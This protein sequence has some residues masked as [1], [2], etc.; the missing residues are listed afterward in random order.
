MENPDNRTKPLD[1]SANPVF[2]FQGKTVG[3][4]KNIPL[5]VSLASLRP[6]FSKLE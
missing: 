4:A 2:E 3:L 1:I 5:G 6:Q